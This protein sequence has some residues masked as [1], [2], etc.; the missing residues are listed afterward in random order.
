MGNRGFSMNKI[1]QWNNQKAANQAAFFR[2]GGD[3]DK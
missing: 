2:T 3:L 1:K